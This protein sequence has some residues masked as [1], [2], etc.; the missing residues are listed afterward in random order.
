MWATVNVTISMLT[1]FV[2]QQLKVAFGWEKSCIVNL[3]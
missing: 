2:L 1:L 3:G